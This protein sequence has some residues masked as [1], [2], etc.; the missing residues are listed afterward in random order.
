MT[1]GDE[2]PETR[3]VGVGET[4]HRVGE[5]HQ[6]AKLTDNEV[7]LIRQLAEGDGKYPPM[8]YR[9]IAEKFEISKTQVYHIV[10]FKRRA[11][12]PVGWRR[13]R[14]GDWNAGRDRD[15]A[16]RQGNYIDDSRSS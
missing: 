4:G 10:H 14:C 3:L 7:E 12:A 6:R 15:A 13:A 16:G 8:A 5:D 9:E 2:P 11:T 1:P